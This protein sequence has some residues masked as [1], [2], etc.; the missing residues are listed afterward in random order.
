MKRTEDAQKNKTGQGSLKAMKRAKEAQNST[1]TSPMN[2]V[3]L[4][5]LSRKKAYNRPKRGPASTRS[6]NSMVGTTGWHDWSVNRPIKRVRNGL[7]KE[8]PTIK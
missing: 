8:R 2:N 4:L 6:N 1:S 7:K 3:G 5:E